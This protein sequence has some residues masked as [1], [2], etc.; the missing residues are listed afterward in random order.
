MEK[1]KDMVLR[2]LFARSS[3]STHTAGRRFF[4]SSSGKKVAAEAEFDGVA[5]A[6]RAKGSSKTDMPSDYDFKTSAAEGASSYGKTQGQG[7]VSYV[8]GLG[9]LGMG[10]FA[11]AGYRS[12][13]NNAR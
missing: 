8:W 12:K 2:S 5:A 7:L 11:F 1:K 10:G 6:A 9:A 3:R 13:T 4:A